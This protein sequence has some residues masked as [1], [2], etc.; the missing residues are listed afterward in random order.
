MLL[1][2][3]KANEEGSELRRTV[4]LGRMEWP[5]NWEM[6]LCNICRSPVLSLSLS[7]SWVSKET[8][9]S[10]MQAGAARPCLPA[11]LLLRACPE[12]NQAKIHAQK[13]GCQL[14][15]LGNA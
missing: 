15:R 12:S 8:R 1:I 7:L 11:P 9:Y 3:S 4:D 5:T 10:L 2:K 6:E 13:R 14:H